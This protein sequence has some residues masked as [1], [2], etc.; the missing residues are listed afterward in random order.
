[1]TVPSTTTTTDHRDGR[2]HR[3]DAHQH[4]WRVADQDQPWRS[5]H[6]AAIARDFLPDELAAS[7]AEV[8]VTRTGTDED[9]ATAG[10]GG[11]GAGGGRVHRGC[12]H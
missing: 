1:M 11:R 2:Q 9:D 8:G 10:S 5:G 6:H 4:F 7:A 3:V 12:A